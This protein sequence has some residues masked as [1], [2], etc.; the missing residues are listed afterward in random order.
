VLLVVDLARV[1]TRWVV[2]YNWKVRY[3]SSPVLEFLRT[4]PYEH[5]VAIFPLDR[6]VDLRRLPPALAQQYQIFAQL[7]GL[8]WTQHLFQ[9]YNIQSLDIVQEPRVAADKAAYEA[10]LAF[11]PVRRWELSNTRYLLG[12]LPLLDLFNQQI[13]TAQK[14]LRVAAGFDL[15]AKPERNESSGLDTITTAINTNGQYAVFDFAGALPRA[16]LYTN[17]KVSTNDPA[18][19]QTWVKDLQSRMPAEMGSALAN[20]DTTNLATLKELADP[21]F[22][23]MKTVLLAEPLPSAGGTSANVGEVKF[24]NYAPKHILL[25]A[26]NTTPAVLLLNDKYDPN[27]QVTVDGQPVKLLR[28]N[29]LMR[30]VFLDKPGAYRIEFKF[31]P[32]ATGLYVS[33]AG[34]ALG[35]GLIGYVGMSRRGVENLPAAKEPAAKNPPRK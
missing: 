24:E 1:D 32:S 22:D 18:A 30:G 8:E 2:T 29:F 21:A 17:W 7:Y 10:A 14:R 20:Q 35:L 16:S 4:R 13:D 25:S 19:L 3:E 34:L 27:W 11:T 12:P 6:F 23:P 26:Q 15:A 9:Y 5:R 33:L 28:C 31:Q